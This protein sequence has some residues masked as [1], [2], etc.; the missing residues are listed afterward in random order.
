MHK[1]DVMVEMVGKFRFTVSK[2]HY[3]LENLYSLFYFKVYNART[4]RN[5]SWIVVYERELCMET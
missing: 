3:V 2:K 4:S 1:F 5:I